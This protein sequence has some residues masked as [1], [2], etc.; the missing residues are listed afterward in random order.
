MTQVSSKSVEKVEAAQ[1]RLEYHQHRQ[2]Q[3]QQWR[4]EF[5]YLGDDDTVYAM[6]FLA[7]AFR[8][9]PSLA[10]WAASKTINGRKPSPV[11]MKEILVK[12]LCQPCCY[13][14][15]ARVYGAW[16]V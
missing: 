7:V 5:G 13:A 8:A 12:W 14:S 3:A 10:K 9:E 16:G 2:R 15:R 4:Q 1:A 6:H 11:E